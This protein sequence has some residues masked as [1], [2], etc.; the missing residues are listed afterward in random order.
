MAVTFSPGDPGG[1]GGPGIPGD[2]VLPLRPG[3]PIGPWIPISPRLP[4]GP[5]M[6]CEGIYVNLSEI[7]IMHKRS[8]KAKPLNV[9]M[10]RQFFF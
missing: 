2:P 6:P 7:I 9:Y 5:V 3:K 10:L 8:K 4:G 1:P